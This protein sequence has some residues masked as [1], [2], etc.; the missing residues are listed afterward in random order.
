M[1]KYAIRLISIS[2]AVRFEFTVDVEHQT[3]EG[4]ALIVVMYVFYM[5]R[6]SL[7]Y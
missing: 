1:I 3:N 2:L 6:Q 4:S 5:P 7:P